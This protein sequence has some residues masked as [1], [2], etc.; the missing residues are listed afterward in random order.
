M[1]VLN[2][3]FTMV[4]TLYFVLITQ[5]LIKELEQ[6]DT[7]CCMIFLV[8]DILHRLTFNCRPHHVRG[9]MLSNG[10]INQRIGQL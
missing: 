1:Q 8:I 9:S 10:F 2:P 6:S 4:D 7:K 3:F 5:L